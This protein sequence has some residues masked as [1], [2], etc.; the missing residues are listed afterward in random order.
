MSGTGR[1]DRS[2]SDA[3]PAGEMS[4]DPRLD[5]GPLRRLVLLVPGL[6]YRGAVGL[7]N[8]L[9]DGGILKATTLPAPS[10]AFGN[11]TVGGTGKTPMTSHVAG[12]LEA[13]GYRVGILSRGYGRR[14]RT[15]LLVSDGRRILADAAAAGDEPWLLARDHPAAGVAVGGDRIAAAA[16]LR[17][18]LRPEVYLLDDA[19]Q[20]RR[21]RRD[22]NIL[23][24]DGG[25]IFGN[26]RILPFG[27]LREPLSGLRRAD[28]VVLTRGD[29]AVPGPLARALERHHPR[30]PIFEARIAPTRFV[31]ADG[32]TADPGALRGLAI[33]AFAGIARPDRFFADLE[34]TGA[35]V[36]GRRAFPDHHPY[37][38]GDFDAIA[39]AASATGAVYLVT[40]EKDLVRLHGR[41]PGA[42]PLGTLAVGV[43]FTAGDFAGFLLDRLAAI[44]AARR[45]DPR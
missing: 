21:V 22:L 16:L 20:H 38:A 26:G 39:R 7:R 3:H 17:E 10:I 6:L 36:L 43:S 35:R 15:P 45:S 11:L 14:G 33:F 18:A 40:T 28:A 13:A 8:R 4:I 27:P 1:S 32:A 24:V 12:L 34:A 44:A 2:R 30:L 42:L 41:P 9:Y 25:T 37:D 19:F 31:G 23:L 29:G 5:P